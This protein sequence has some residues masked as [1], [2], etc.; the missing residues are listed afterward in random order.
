MK[1]LI[2]LTMIIVFISAFFML[3]VFNTLIFPPC[4][5]EVCG[6]DLPTMLMGISA[7][8]GF[9]LLSIVAVYIVTK[10]LITA[11]IGQGRK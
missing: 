7:V 4:V 6:T 2:V 11:D 8:V 1:I 10:T 5:E 3:F 9:L